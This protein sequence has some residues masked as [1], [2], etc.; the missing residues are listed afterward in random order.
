MNQGSLLEQAGLLCS[1]NI[2]QG[3]NDDIF[4]LLG[5]VTESSFLGGVWGISV[6]GLWSRTEDWFLQL[7]SSV[8][9]K[10][11]HAIDCQTDSD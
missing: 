7:I 1:L 9:A 3:W 6:M 5:W 10:H 11:S 8:L 4:C 2:R